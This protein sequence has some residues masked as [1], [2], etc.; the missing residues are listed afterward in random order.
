[1]GSVM[2]VVLRIFV[3][4]VDLCILFAGLC[5]LCRYVLPVCKFV[6]FA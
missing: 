2:G 3:Y 5:C 1:M 4:S 6:L